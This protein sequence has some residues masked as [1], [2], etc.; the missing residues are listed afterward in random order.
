MLEPQVFSDERGYFLETY[1]EKS[2]REAGIT[3]RFVQ[4]NY[5]HSRQHV[6][7]GLHFQVDKPQSKLI[8]VIHG[9]IF[10]VVVD[11]RPESAS[12]GKWMGTNLSGEKR[13]LLWIPAGFAHGFYVLSAT[14]DLT[15][16][17]SNFYDR[18]DERTLLW[19]DPDLAIQ[20]PLRGE[21]VLSEKD[22][23]G[24]LLRHL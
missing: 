9:E 18:S 12:Y 15:Y 21:P 10:D 8:R 20:W 13:Q 24:T 7:R 11:L 3:E 5:S 1:N 16:K 23:A 19:N 2:F 6:L 22:K 14:A 17:V 4:D